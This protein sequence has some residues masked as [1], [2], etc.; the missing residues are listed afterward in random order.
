MAKGDDLYKNAPQNQ[1][2]NDNAIYN[3]GGL[4]PPQ[5]MGR[6][7][8][9][10]TAKRPGEIGGMPAPA[11]GGIWEML[12]SLFPNMMGGSGNMGNGQGQGSIFNRLRGGIDKLKGPQ[13]QPQKPNERTPVN[14][15]RARATDSID[16]A[17]SIYAGGQRPLPN[18][19]R[20]FSFRPQFDPMALMNGGG[21]NIMPMPR[22]PITPQFDEQ[23]PMLP[24]NANN[25]QFNLA[26]LFPG[27][28]GSSG[29]FRQ[30]L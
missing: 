14:K 17:S 16:R 28:M 18:P 23:M 15:G 20:N 9:G 29:N 19:D 13:Q 6:G 7:I 26:S 8:M 3:R 25:P 30:M 5:P 24:N 22:V 2:I 4:K 10:P 1:Q 27:M 12:Q 11:Q 21:G